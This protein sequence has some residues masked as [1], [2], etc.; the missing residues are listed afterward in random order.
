MQAEAK[1]RALLNEKIWTVHLVKCLILVLLI[2]FALIELDIIY[3]GF[4]SKPQKADCIIVPGCKV[5]G[6]I[7]TPFLAARLDKAL[8]LYHNGYSNRFI[9]S[10]GR[11]RGE[12]MS[13][14]KCMRNYLAARGVNPDN[15][16]VEDHSRSTME[17]IRNSHREMAKKGFHS[18]IIVSN[19]FHLKRISCLARQQRL[20]A[21]YAGVFRARYIFDE[22]YGFLREVPA[23]L[24]T[25][26]KA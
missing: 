20:P 16:I 19:C 7:P 18:A 24:I 26:L 5:D 1:Q 11:G 25:W 4:S 2:L 17:N 12:D 15:I 3:F 9:V 14:A 6:S 23:L 22:S 8:Q 10:G 21:S 13:E